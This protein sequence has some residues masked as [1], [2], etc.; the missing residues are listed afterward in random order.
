[1]RRLL[2]LVLL[3]SSA[4]LARAPVPEPAEVLSLT[5]GMERFLQERVVQHAASPHA[6]HELL[7][8]AVFGADGIG[9]HYDAVSTRS[10]SE[11]FESG[12]GNCLSFT[13]MYVAMARALGL[14]VDYQEVDEPVWQ[15]QGDTVLRTSHINVLLRIQGQ[16]RVVDFEPDLRF[17]KARLR[18]VGESRALAHFY[19]NRGMETL[20]AGDPE[21]A[22][23]WVERAIEVDAGFVPA[24]SNLGVVQRQL[25]RESEAETAYLRA[26]A[27]DPM[28]AQSLSNLAG[29]Y[30]QWQD[31]TRKAGYV[32]RLRKVQRDDP[33]AAYEQGRE[34]ERLGQLGLAAR[35]YRRAARLHP[36]DESFHLALFRVYYLMGNEERAAISLMRA[37]Q[38]ASADDPSPYERKF[39]ALGVDPSRLQVPALDHGAGPSQESRHR[40]GEIAPHSRLPLMRRF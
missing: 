34:Q 10:V 26:L 40:L 19:N 37:S 11:T 20:L 2:L 7:M 32:L 12:S 33:Y 31:E 35:H 30:E 16:N 23:A 38:L 1:M 36:L 9:M 27:L 18:R 22:Q 25:G 13:L 17:G 14:E 8:Q 5:Q 21:T 24:W 39:A 4:A 29:L 3:A 6:R 15:R 28:H